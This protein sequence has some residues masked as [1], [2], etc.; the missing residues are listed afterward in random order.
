[1][2]LPEPQNQYLAQAIEDELQ[3][4]LDDYS[5]ADLEAHLYNHMQKVEQD[6]T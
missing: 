5:E 6:E 1:M 2:R 3:G 4:Y